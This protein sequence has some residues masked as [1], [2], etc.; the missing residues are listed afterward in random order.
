MLTDREIRIAKPR[1]ERYEI[2]DCNG[3][4]V[5]VLP[6][7]KKF[8][9]HRKLTEGKRSKTTIGEYPT[10]SLLDARDTIAMMGINNEIP[11]TSP[12]ILIKGGNSVNNK[13]AA[14][15]TFRTVF[16]DWYNH[17]VKDVVAPRHEKTIRLR[18]NR[19]ILSKLGD[20]TLR[21]ITAP[22]ILAIARTLEAE[23]KRETAHRI[24]QM[25]GS[26]MRYGI[27]TGNCEF[28][29]TQSLKGLLVPTR[30]AHR[31]ALQDTDDIGRL[32]LGI[33]GY[34]STVTRC[35]LLML[36]YTFVRSKEL[37][38]AEWKEVNLKTAEWRIPAEKMKMKSTHIVPLSTQCIALLKKIKAI[39]CGQYIF[40]SPIRRSVKESPLTDAAL[41]R[42]LRVLGYK[43]DLMCV[44][45]FR[46]IACTAL[47]ESGSWGPDAIER[48]MA[49]SERSSVRAAYN[50]AQYL[51]ERRKMMQWYADWL[52]GLSEN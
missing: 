8:F 43:K 42:V 47:N 17:K 38:C 32:M 24:V 39:S 25:I 6:S 31:P 45:G 2:S 26:V 27:G 10:V 29:P 19:H 50:Y 51:P 52:D 5:E 14:E 44:H 11:L 18:A 49:H 48:Q 16:T 15:V 36:A 23:G 3:L 1:K 46:S 37:R 12:E 7:G 41:I 40:P 20:K 34:P 9:R 13:T 35:A 4:Y 30:A 21:S 33:H 28:D 22:A